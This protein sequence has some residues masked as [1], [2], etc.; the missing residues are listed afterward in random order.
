MA[1]I[2][3]S[4]A[5]AIGTIAFDRDDKRN[6]LSAELIAETISALDEFRTQDAR[7]VVLRSATSGKVWSAGHDV[8]ELPVADVD[9]LPYDDPLEQLIR[10]V[11]SFPAPVVAM[12]HGSVWG[13]A[14]DL[15]MACDLVYAD[16]TAAFAITPAKLGLPYNVGG[17]LNFMSR[18]PLNVVKEMFF[19]AEPITADR[20]ERVGIVNET[21][22]ADELE[23]TVYRMARTITTRSSAAIAAAKESIRVL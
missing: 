15:I 14:C 16:D 10:A 23:D 1:L 17:F 9:P 6:A 22:P 11:K 5:E 7:V 21:V 8:A 12:V 2:K 13:G 20:A 19:S 4:L 3:T 18:L